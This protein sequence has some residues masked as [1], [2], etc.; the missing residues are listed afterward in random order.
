M[1][2]ARLKLAFITA[3]FAVV[4]LLRISWS[5][6]LTL[7]PFF[8]L[9]SLI[10]SCPRVSRSVDHDEAGGCAQWRSPRLLSTRLML[11][12]TADITRHPLT[13]TAP[14]C[15]CRRHAH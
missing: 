13:A 7:F 1:V 4:P 12:Q 11:Q 3:C 9:Y 15:V 6:A 10:R 2:A 14:G 8:L 5:A